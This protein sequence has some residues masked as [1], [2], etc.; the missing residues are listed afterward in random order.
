MKTLSSREIMGELRVFGVSKKK[1]LFLYLILYKSYYSLHYCRT[2]KK[3]KGLKRFVDKC[4]R[5]YDRLNL[6]YINSTE[7]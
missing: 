1:D 3:I 7:I 2:F 5:K 4:L 6:C